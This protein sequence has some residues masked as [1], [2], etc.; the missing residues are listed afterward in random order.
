MIAFICLFFPAV[1]G[2]WLFEHLRKAPLTRRE[3]FYRYCSNTIFV[4]GICFMAK[5]FLLD[6]GCEA[7]ADITPAAGLN[8]LIMAVPTALIFGFL[9][10]VFSKCAAITVEEQEDA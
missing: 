2:V 3:L 9:Q 5:R 7:F 8:Y 1:L 10:M 6:T 4:N